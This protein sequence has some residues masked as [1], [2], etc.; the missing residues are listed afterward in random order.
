MNTEKNIING[1]E[2]PFWNQFIENKAQWIGGILEDH[3]GGAPVAVTTITDI[4]LRPKGTESAFFEVQGE[5]FTC[6]FDVQY[7]GVTAGEPGW[8]T[9][10]VYHDHT[11]R[12]KGPVPTPQAPMQQ[13][14]PALAA[15][16]QRMTKEGLTG[17]LQEW[18]S[19]LSDL[20]AALLSSTP[21]MDPATPLASTAMEAAR[22]LFPAWT[23]DEQTDPL[24][25]DH[26][27]YFAAII[28]KHFQPLLAK[29]EG[30]RDAA[31]KQ[32]ADLEWKLSSMKRDHDIEKQGGE[33]Q[34]R[35]CCA[36]QV[37]A[38]A[39]RADLAAKEA[40]LVK[41]HAHLCKEIQALSLNESAKAGSQSL[42]HE[43][44]VLLDSSALASRADKGGAT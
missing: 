38:D 23:R 22:D 4:V 13:R 6:G 42:L 10:T 15:H 11:W 20:N 31:V 18:E 44:S 27:S 5:E 43:I 39:L 8:I 24:A 33:A 7:G 16:L 40:A 25:L 34:Y 37:V 1:R 9:F 19:F 2:Y 30:G 29:V 36:L 3:T 28:Q 41:C 21:T 35:N 12:I 26:L 14:F 32:V 17:T